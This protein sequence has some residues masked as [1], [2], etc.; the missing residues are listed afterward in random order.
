MSESAVI[1]QNDESEWDDVKDDH[2]HYAQAETLLKACHTQADRRLWTVEGR[3]RQKGVV[4]LTLYPRASMQAEKARTYS[5][6]C[7]A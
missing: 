5:W 7:A 1:V 2:Y 6:W 4:Y 3:L